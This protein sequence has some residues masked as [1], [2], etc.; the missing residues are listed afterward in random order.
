MT[1]NDETAPEI[2]RPRILLEA[3][4]ICARGYKRETMLPRLLGAN[5]AQ[6]VAL[7]TEREQGLEATRR[8]KEGAYSA[9]VHVEVL[10]A[11]IAESRAAA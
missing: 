7:L 2:R 8:A 6:V 11:L 5:T 1:L 10:S 9:R 4:R 3:A